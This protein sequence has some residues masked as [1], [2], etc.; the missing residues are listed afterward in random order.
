MGWINFTLTVLFFGSMEVVSKPFMGQIDPFALTLFRFI[1]GF[2]FLLGFNLVYNRKTFL[3][4]SG[5]DFI[6]MAFLGFLNT[7]FSM[8]MLQLAVHHTTAATTALIFSSNPLFVLLL[9]F[10]FGRERFDWKKL[11]FF[12]LGIAG[13]F[14]L[15]FERGLDLHTGAIYA[16][17]AA[18]SFALYTFLNKG[19]VSRV[20][21]ITANVIS[22]FFGII[23]L[24]GYIWIADVPLDLQPALSSTAGILRLLYLGLIVSGV[25]Y[26]TFFFALKH[27]TA[28]AASLIFMIKPAVATALSVML[29][30]E[31]LEWDFFVGLFLILAATGGYF[32]IR[33]TETKLKGAA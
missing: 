33:H 22:F 31:N 21:P 30:S 10:A 29:L 24:S 18:V 25:G 26:I 12:L 8:S 7:F 15:M 11:A 32:H 19:L 14:L 17:A 3:G 4:I 2:C 23:W 5:K 13:L 28:S 27:Y 20:H 16:I 9:S 6:L 1:I